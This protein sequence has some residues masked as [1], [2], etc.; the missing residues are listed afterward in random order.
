VPR[1]PE[2]CADVWSDLHPVFVIQGHDMRQTGLCVFARVDGSYL[3]FAPP[4]IATVP[5]L[6]FHFLDV[7]AVG[8]HKGEQI[9]RAFGGKYLARET[10]R[11]QLWQQ[12]RMVNM[13]VGLQHKIDIIGPEKEM[14]RS[15][16]P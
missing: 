7:A 11:G 4:L 2:P 1:V 10:R 13:R 14:V 16:T 3:G 5:M 6:Y 15:S 9:P 12:T 8:Q